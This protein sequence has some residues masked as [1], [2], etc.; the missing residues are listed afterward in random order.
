MAADTDTG[1]IAIRILE[2][3]PTA[4]WLSAAWADLKRSPGVSLGYG[5]ALS[6]LSWA[7]TLAVIAGEQWFLVLPLLGGF[8]F[9]AP[10]IAVGLYEVSRRHEAG[11]PVTITDA[12]CAARHNGG[13]IAFMGLILALFFLAWTRLAL[14]L[15]ALFFGLQPPPFADL[16]GSIFLTT[17]NLAFILISNAIG[18]VLAMVVFAISAISIPMLLDRRTD[19]ITAV[20]TSVRACLAN[21]RV[22]IGWAALIVLMVALGTISFYLG[23]AIAYPLIG[24]ATWAAYR[25]LVPAPGEE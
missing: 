19:V 21:W 25:D 12:L 6:L 22:M 18:L 3:D 24:H 20:A 4:R 11:L 8:M 14:L 17:D 10:L 2:G 1:R 16:I 13:Q 23:L 7:V 15:F 9:L 5:L